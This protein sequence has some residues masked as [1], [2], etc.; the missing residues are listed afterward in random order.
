MADKRSISRV[1]L[2]ILQ[3]VVI[4]GLVVGGL[5]TC[6]YLGFYSGKKI[7]LEEALETSLAASMKIPVD[8]SINSSKQSLSEVYDSLN[9][10]GSAEKKV[11]SAGQKSSAKSIAAIATL[12]EKPI[13]EI[14]VSPTKQEKNTITKQEEPQ[15]DLEAIRRALIGNTKT[16]SEGVTVKEIVRQEDQPVAKDPLDLHKRE[17]LEEKSGEVT[18]VKPTSNPLVVAEKPKA[19][20][21]ALPTKTA[22]KVAPTPNRR[23]FDEETVEEKSATRKEAVS[24]GIPRGWYAQVAAPPTEEAANQL[25]KKLRASG[26]EVALEKAEVRDEHYYRVLVGPEQSRELAN[27][28]LQE[29]KRETYIRS[30]PFIRMVR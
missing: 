4:L 13:P 17:T 11:V 3:V 15:D 29:L 2:S 14:V 21:N 26:F 24:S 22:T 7:G 18:N 16:A 9:S 28:M 30:E 27:R 12:E 25:V 10:D 5:L 6:F 19:T 23:V 20:P 1:N 8:S